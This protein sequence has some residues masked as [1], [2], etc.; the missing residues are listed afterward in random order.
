[1]GDSLYGLTG[2]TDFTSAGL[3]GLESTAMYQQWTPQQ[4]QDYILQ[5]PQLSQK[6]GYL[7][8]GY[9]FNTYQQ[10]KLTNAT[11]LKQR[12]GTQYT[13]AQAI[14][15]LTEPQTAFHAQG[16]TFGEFQPYVQSQ[17][18]IPTGRQSSVR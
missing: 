5:N 15:S 12:Y 10:Y 8:A 13:D 4:L 1:M 9:T 7:K 2:H 11:A 6:Y 16:G 14:Q 17:T 18:T 3:A